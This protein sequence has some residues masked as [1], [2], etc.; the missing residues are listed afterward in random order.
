MKI[1][2]LTNIPSPYRVDF[3]NELGKCV[4][5]TVIFE[6]SKSDERDKSWNS[7]NF[8]NFKGTI[9]RGIS[10]G[11][12]SALS[13]Q[14]LKYLNSEYD[15]VVVTNASTPTGILAI[16]Y[17]QLYKISYI[18][19]GDGGTPRSGKGMKEKLKMVLN[20]NAVAWFSSGLEHDK[21][22]LKYGSNKDKIFRYPFTSIRNS[23]I[24][25]RALSN[26]E[27]R[28]I[29]KELGMPLVNK[30]VIAVGRFVESKGFESL[31][32]SWKRVDSSVS[33]FII[34][35]G[36]EREKYELMIKENELKNIYLLDHL[37]K[38]ILRKYYLASDLFVLPTKGDAWGLVINEA[39]ACGLPVITTDRCIAGLELIDDY[40]NGYIVQVEDVEMLSSR[41]IEIMGDDELR[42]KMSSNNIRTISEYT[43]ENMAEIHMKYFKQLLG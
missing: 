9:M 14:V 5:L 29:R 16:I 30:I 37:D 24:I 8:I 12:D 17:M 6:K 2:W 32:E 20:K 10:T 36:K 21:Y 42:Y 7:F 31:I 13:L 11:Y 34:G 3:F 18:I 38:D 19:E 40:E 23:D 25:S 43:I 4:N 1:L 39:M 35:G 22:Y 28:T 26:E 27:K 41:I 15:I 33:L